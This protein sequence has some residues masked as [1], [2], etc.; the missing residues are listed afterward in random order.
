MM[1][2]LKSG[3][4][5]NKR[6]PKTNTNNWKVEWFFT[7]CLK[8][9]IGEKSPNKLKAKGLLDRAFLFSVFAGSPDFDIKEIE[10]PKD[11][12]S[13]EVLSRLLDLRKL[14]LVYRLIHFND[15]IPDLDVGVI[16]RNKEL[17]KPYIRLFYGSKS[18]KEVEQTFQTLLD[19]K[20][21]KKSIN[22]ELILIPPL[23]DLVESNGTALIPSRD[24][25]SFLK[26]NFDPNNELEYDKIAISDYTVYKTTITRILEDKFGAKPKHCEK[27]NVNHF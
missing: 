3:Y 16:R 14:M 23:V 1:N 11:P 9:I 20:S 12:R 26:S 22:I 19:I 25:W 10:N 4:N 21:E 15:T 24:V 8:I 7:Y 27:G 18:Q 17:C 6:V 2:I 5:F 13:Q